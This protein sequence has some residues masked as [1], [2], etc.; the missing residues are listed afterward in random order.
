MVC[1]KGHPGLLAATRSS[2]R[3]RVK[4]SL[5]ASGKT[6]PTD[7]LIL[8]FWPAEE[9]K[10]LSNFK[11]PHL[12]VICYGSLRKEHASLALSFPAPL[13][14]SPSGPDLPWFSSSGVLFSLDVAKWRWAS[15][16]SGWAGALPQDTLLWIYGP[17]PHFA[18]F[19]I[20]SRSLWVVQG[21]GLGLLLDS[22]VY[23]VGSQ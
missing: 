16:S 13:Q 23:S 6:N 1:A 4:F 15:V 7:I 11:H 5:R 3:D 21:H 20:L 12:V 17:P 9:S 8:D 18:Y 2:E 19:P 10:F 22:T 14:V